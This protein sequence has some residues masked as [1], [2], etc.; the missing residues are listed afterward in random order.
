MARREYIACLELGGF[1]IKLGVSLYLTEENGVRRFL[2]NY[3]AAVP[4]GI[5]FNKGSIQNVYNLKASLKE[6]FDAVQE[7]LK[8]PVEDVYVDGMGSKI[9]PEKIW[10][11]VE[12]NVRFNQTQ[13]PLSRRM[14]SP[15]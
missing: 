9:T 10:P 14:R 7:W 8:F 13:T 11:S 3:V 1:C 6:L 12:C 2:G 5:G 15:V 4:M